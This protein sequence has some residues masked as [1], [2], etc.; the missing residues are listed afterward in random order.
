MGDAVKPQPYSLDGPGGHSATLEHLFLST[1]CV[2]LSAT[3]GSRCP[4]N[5]P[6]IS[7]GDKSQ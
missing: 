4:A 6:V 2:P 5:V 7:I 3:G 1:D